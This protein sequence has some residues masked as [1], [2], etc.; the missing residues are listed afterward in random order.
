MCSSLIA[1]LVPVLHSLVSTKNLVGVSILTVMWLDLANKILANE[2]HEKN[3]W[4]WDWS[5]SCP[6][7]LPWEHIHI[8]LLEDENYMKQ[9]GIA[10][11][12]QPRPYWTWW[13]SVNH[14]T[15]KG[16]QR[17][18]ELPSQAQPKLA[19]TPTH[20]LN[21]SV[22]WHAVSCLLWNIIVAIDTWYTTLGE[23][24]KYS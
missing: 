20:E 12:S 24:V 22:F 23:L 5:C 4:N 18:P 1:L 8:S 15:F 17:R 2:M 7:L 13:Q 10:P 9:S 21:N 11:V 6:L 16:V 3:S 19:N 14:H